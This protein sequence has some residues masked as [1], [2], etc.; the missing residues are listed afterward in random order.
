MSRYIS[1][2]GEKSRQEENK[3]GKQPMVVSLFKSIWWRRQESNLRPSA[4][5]ADALPTELRPRGVDE[6]NITQALHES[7]K[8]FAGALRFIFDCRLLFKLLPGSFLPRAPPNQSY[9]WGRAPHPGVLTKLTW[10]LVSFKRF[11]QKKRLE[12]VLTSLQGTNEVV[13]WIHSYYGF[14]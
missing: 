2:I 10:I 5:K 1:T 14:L 11:F 13:L 12:R 3:K 6:E 8:I 4:C 7:K 9:L